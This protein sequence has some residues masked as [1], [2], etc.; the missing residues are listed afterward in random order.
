METKNRVMA[1]V[2]VLVALV[3]VFYLITNTITSTTGYFV[4]DVVEKDKAFIECLGEKDIV[5]YLNSEDIALS[6]ENIQAREFL[7][8]V[9]IFNCYRNNLACVEQGVGSFPTWIFSD[10][11]INRDIT[12]YELSEMS[13]CDLR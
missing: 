10:K 2:G 12:I 5:L 9:S 7:G 1:T 4:S 3:V 11:K 13:G 8:G 6:L